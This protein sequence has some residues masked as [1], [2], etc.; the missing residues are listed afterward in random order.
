M[1][2]D[3]KKQNAS[4]DAESLLNTNRTKMGSELSVETGNKS[5]RKQRI[6]SIVIVLSVI[7][8]LAAVFI[9]GGIVSKLQYEK[10]QKEE[11][12]AARLAALK[13]ARPDTIYITGEEPELM[14]YRVTWSAIYA[15]YSNENGMY[16]TMNFA[17]GHETAVPVTEI[18][19]WLKRGEELVASG[20][21]RNIVDLVIPAAGDTD[22]T[23]YLDPSLVKITDIE[24]NVDLEWELQ[25]TT[26][27]DEESQKL[28]KEKREDTLVIKGDKP[29]VEAGAVTYAVT[30][31]YYT[32]E[33]GMY[34]TLS[35][36]NG[37]ETALDIEEVSVKLY[38]LV[39]DSEEKV[40][41]ASGDLSIEQATNIPAGGMATYTYYFEPE[42]V[43]ITELTEKDPIE[44]VI[45]Y[46]AE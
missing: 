6:I 17:N 15:Y 20:R 35:F 5:S 33:D 41:V 26:D 29:Q 22:Y 23:F 14:P 43:E 25:V 18:S 11:A 42:S 3:K 7:A 24:E 19:V 39:A 16:I 46:K 44:W 8:A 10:Q 12:E 31:A 45:E 37:T 36:A 28:A 34:M 4:Y 9:L 1:N 32:N 21:L 30:E 2:Q 38:S 13:E 40:L 27:V